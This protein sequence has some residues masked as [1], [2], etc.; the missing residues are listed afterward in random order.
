[1]Y[2]SLAVALAIAA[3]PMELAET[4]R[5]HVK[6]FGDPSANAQHFYIVADQTTATVLAWVLSSCSLQQEIEQCVP[7]KIEGRPLWLIDLGQF[8][9]DGSFTGLGWRT[10]DWQEVLKAH[11]YGGYSRVIRGDWLVMELLDSVVS[12]SR[13]EDGIA[14]YYRLLYRGSPPKTEDEFLKFWEIDTNEKKYLSS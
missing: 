13:H 7:Q 14:S 5:E 3:R 6:Q 12:A 9:P 4:A 8:F 10:E 11:P 2:Y 1:M